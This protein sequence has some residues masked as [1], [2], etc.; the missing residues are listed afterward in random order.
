MLLGRATEESRA[1]PPY[2]FDS[3]NRLHDVAEMF[4]ALA[5]QES[6][7]A[8]PRD[9]I[10]Y[11]ALLEAPLGRP[12][13][14]RAQAER[15]NK[16]RVAWKHFGAE[17]AITEVEAARTT[18]TAL[19]EG[20]CVAL[21]GVDLVDVSLTSFV[22]PETARGLVASAETAWSA[23]KEQD[24][25]GDLAEAFDVMIGDYT[26]RREIGY[27][28]SL[29]SGIPD[30]T[31]AK[32]RGLDYDLEKLFDKLID[33]VKAVDTTVTLIGIGVD[34]RRLSRFRMLTP[35]ITRYAM[36]HRGT[37][38]PVRKALRT[39]QDFNYCRDFIIDT[40]MHLAVFDFDVDAD[41]YVRGQYVVRRK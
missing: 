2:C 23:N 25:F 21:F 15:F 34:L 36:G 3:V 24:A 7:L 35:Q 17:P 41:N 13:G 26:S 1:A 39:D 5:A 8:S 38:E 14:Y 28:M 33:G 40:A 16:V 4:L 12:L 10:G 31:F 19:L 11:W 27:G 37:D 9:F 22:H 18:V 32:P 20:E 6:A 30:F 29:L